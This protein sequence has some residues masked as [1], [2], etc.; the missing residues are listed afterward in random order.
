[1]FLQQF[2]LF[3]LLFICCVSFQACRTITA[4]SRKVNWGT[5]HTEHCDG[6]HTVLRMWIQGAKILL[7]QILATSNRNEWDV[8]PSSATLS[9]HVR[10]SVCQWLMSDARQ[11][12]PNIRDWLD[13][14]MQFSQLGFSAKFESNQLLLLLVLLFVF[15][16]SCYKINWF[17][18]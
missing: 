1:M 5:V 11:H 8:C 17:C 14:L 3:C 16:L 12:S 18:T 9:G 4:A 13:H 15:W 2:Y 6:H 7:K 10:P